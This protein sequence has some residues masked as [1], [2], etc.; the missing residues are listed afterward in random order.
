[1]LG[2]AAPFEEPACPGLAEVCTQCCQC[3]DGCPAG[4]ITENGF[5]G[6]QCR[7]YRKERAEYEPVGDEQV[8]R[9]CVLCAQVCPIGD[10]PKLASPW[11]AL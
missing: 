5:E 11:S 4:A 8:Y 3:V 9:W 2:T 1:V 7:A 6:L 10:R